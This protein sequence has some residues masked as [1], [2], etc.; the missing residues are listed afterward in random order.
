MLQKF[1]LGGF[2]GLIEGPR[3]MFS[4]QERTGAGTRRKG[5]GRTPPTTPDPHAG[6]E[7]PPSAMHSTPLKQTRQIVKKQKFTH[8][9]QKFAPPE[10][11]KPQV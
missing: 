10:P 8:P 9:E 6:A 7:V 1:L 4:F 3:H 5:R 11:T 2:I